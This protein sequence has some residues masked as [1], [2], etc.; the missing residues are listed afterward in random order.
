MTWCAV[1]VRSP[2]DTRGA[3]ASWMVERTG[4]AV[5]ERDDGTLVGFAATERDAG[6]LVRA[7]DARFGPGVRGTARVLPEVDWSERWRDG[8]APRSIG[9]LIVAPSWTAAGLDPATTVIIDPESAFG[10]GEH[11]STRAALALLGRHLRPGGLVIDLG[12]GSGILAIAAVK[13]GA[14]RAVGIEIDPEAEPVALANA[15]RNGV[16]GRVRFLTGDA[17]PLAP[18]VGPAGLVVANILRSANVSL[19]TVVR[20]S[21]VPDGLAVFS[22]MERPERELFLPELERA[23]FEAFDELVDESWWAVAARRR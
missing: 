4:Q 3:V 1:D 8:L 7:L 11:G 9:P 19:L 14:A 6:E 12:S 18:L 13:L 17:A 22:G 5:E 15:E 2:E 23:G 10:T 16:T 20:E 21:L